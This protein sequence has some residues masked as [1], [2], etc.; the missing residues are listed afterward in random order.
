MLPYTQRILGYVSIVAIS[1]SKV[2]AKVL[3]FCDYVMFYILQ[4]LVVT[5]KFRQ[6]RLLE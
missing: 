4:T 5:I 3:L 1:V 6:I 2:W